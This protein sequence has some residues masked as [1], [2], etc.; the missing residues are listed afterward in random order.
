MLASKLIAELQKFVEQY[1]DCEVAYIDDFDGYSTIENINVYKE[2]N[3][4]IICIE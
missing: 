1:G 2:G 3:E 4:T